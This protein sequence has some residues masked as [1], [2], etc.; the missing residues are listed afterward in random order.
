L[1]YSEGQNGKMIVNNRF[2]NTYI[3]QVIM[4]NKP[5]FLIQPLQENLFLK[6]FL[7]LYVCFF[8]GIA[9]PVHH[10]S[11]GLDHDDCAFCTMQNHAPLAE[12]VFSLPTAAGSIVELPQPPRRNYIPG[13]L[14]AFKSRAPPALIPVS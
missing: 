3:G 4:R 5:I 11:D 1:K 7:S 2:C 14:S 8:L 9:L 10:H 6:I 12:T 13:I